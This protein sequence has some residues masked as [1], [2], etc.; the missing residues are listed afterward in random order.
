MTVQE[1]ALIEL[2]QQVCFCGGVRFV[3]AGGV[4][5]LD[6]VTHPRQYLGRLLLWHQRCCVAGDG[7]ARPR[8]RNTGLYLQ[9]PCKAPAERRVCELNWTGEVFTIGFDGLSGVT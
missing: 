9:I 2:A 7:M 3:G 4:A 1:D 8:I 5:V 6:T